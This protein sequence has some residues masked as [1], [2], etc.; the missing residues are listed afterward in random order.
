MGP[1]VDSERESSRTE[2]RRSPS[3]VE[4]G[5]RNMTTVWP[6]LVSHAARRRIWV[7]LPEPSRPS[8]VMNKPRGM[9]TSLSHEV[10]A[11][12]LRAKSREVKNNKSEAASG[13]SNWMESEAKFHL[14]HTSRPRVQSYPAERHRFDSRIILIQKI[15]QTWKG[16]L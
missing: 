11:A 10:G 7:V 6:E 15:D 13:E 12:E 16:E 1:S 5:W 14:L 4:P 2:R 9:G 3:A 8:K